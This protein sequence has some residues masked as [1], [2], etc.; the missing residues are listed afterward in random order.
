VKV[1]AQSY[2]GTK[3]HRNAKPHKLIVPKAHSS[4]SKSKRHIGTKGK[5]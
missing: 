4:K 1:K 2:Q 5:D 3:A